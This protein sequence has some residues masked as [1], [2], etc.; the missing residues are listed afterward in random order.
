MVVPHPIH[1]NPN[2]LLAPLGCFA[3]FSHLAPDH[4]SLRDLPLTLQDI[5]THAETLDGI[6]GRR[7]KRRE[8]E[9]VGSEEFGRSGGVEELRELGKKMAEQEARW[10]RGET[11]DAD[12][13]QEGMEE[14]GGGGAA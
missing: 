3:V 1:P 2:P 11:E 7:R 12:K 14:G 4:K 9:G 8:R 10:Q 13:N 5:K 6:W